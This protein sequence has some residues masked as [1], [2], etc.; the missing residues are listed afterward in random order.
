MSELPEPVSRRHMHTRDIVCEGFLRDDGL[1]DIEASLRDTKTY[2]FTETYR[3]KRGPADPVHL[4]HVRL[5]IDDSL[6]VHDIAVAMPETPYPICSESAANFKS[7]I[8][9]QIGSSW[10]SEVNKRVG[11]TNGCTHVRELLFPMATVAIQTI[12]GWGEDNPPKDK[13]GLVGLPDDTTIKPAFINGCY[14]WSDKRAMIAEIYPLF[15]KTEDSA[16]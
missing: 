2:E 5:T 15:A 8:G 1:W 14:A 12:K 6:T 13:P 10:R 16:D 11:R 4:M 3:G 7:I 9:L